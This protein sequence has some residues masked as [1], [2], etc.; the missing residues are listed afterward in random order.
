[1]SGSSKNTTN[2]KNE[3]TPEQRELV[4]LQTEYA[5]YVAPNAKW[6]NDTGRALMQDSLADMQLDYTNMNKLAQQQLAEANAGWSSLSQGILPQEYINNKQTILNNVAQNSVG[7]VLNKLGQSGVINSSVMNTSLNDISKNVAN[8]MSESYNND[9]S[10]L[11][12]IYGQLASNAGQ[13]IITAAAAQEAQMEP[14]LQYWNASLGLGG[15]GNSA[16]G[17]I[18]SK[19]NTTQTQSTGNGGMWSG[20]LSA[21]A[22][23][24][25]LFL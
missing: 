16:L 7:N 21:G 10:S 6:A 4:K 2:V 9:I 8:A 25:P 15:A 18:A 14:G 1:M 3:L 24:A 13:N 12:G 19:G 23:I 5:R 11:S 20:I 22:N 17:A